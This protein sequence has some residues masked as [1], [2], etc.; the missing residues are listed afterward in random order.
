MLFENLMDYISSIE[1]D[2]ELIRIEAEIDPVYELAEV[3]HQLNISSANRAIL[4]ENVK[5]CTFPVVTNLYGSENRICKGLSVSSL[6]DLGSLLTDKLKTEV[7]EGLFESIK[8]IPQRTQLGKLL[9]KTIRNGNCQQ[10][11]KMGRDV[12]LREFPIVHSWPSETSMSITS[13]NLISREPESEINHVENITLEARDPQSFYI[14]W[15]PHDKGYSD[16]LEYRKR[17]QQMPVAISL[18]GDASINLIASASMPVNIDSWHLA[19]LLRNQS[20]SL[21]KCRSHDL[22]IPADSEMIIEG[23]IDTTAKLEMAGSVS[24]PFGYSTE[25]AESPVLQITAITHRSNPVYPTQIRCQSSQEQYWIS[26]ATERLILPFVQFLLPEVTDLHQPFT[27]AN[28][29]SLFV[30]IKKQYPFQARKVMQMLWSLPQFL[31]TKTIVVVDHSI[32]IQ[33]EKHVWWQVGANVHPERDTL[34]IDGPTDHNDHASPQRNAGKKMGIDA[35]AKL[36]EEG[37]PRDWP[38]ILESN[39]ST[40]E[41]VKRRW[42]EYG[43]SMSLFE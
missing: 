26:K 2:G 3:V 33:N 29:F 43:L 15:G 17:D 7:P 31:S 25:P 42:I 13:G 20:L 35:T 41:K 5:G 28:K 32:N 34:F 22:S 23:M 21:V 9:P 10:I 6:N 19:G 12:N 37:H 40:R 30:S 4:F 11:V 14:H 24:G 36:P 38:E 18:G 39:Q 1:E 16:Y 8:Q 27:G